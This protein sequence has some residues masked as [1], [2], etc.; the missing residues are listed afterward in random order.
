MKNLISIL[1]YTFLLAFVISSCSDDMDLPMSETDREIQQSIAESDHS[2]HRNCG[3]NHVMD[4]LMKDP[5]YQK[6]H[7][8]KL[9]K[10]ASMKNNPA[11]RS[12]CSN[13][14][15]IP[16]AVHF[17][18]VSGADASCLR[19]LAQSQIDILNN[20]F[21]GSNSD[22]SKWNNSAASFFPNISNGEACVK[23]VLATKN[24]PSGFGLSEGAIAVTI[25]KVQGTESS[26]FSGYLNIFVQPN[27]GFLGESP[28]GGAGNGDGVLVD[29]SA[30][31]SGAGCGNV[32]PESPYNLGRTLTT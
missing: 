22:I 4:K 16:V 12:A 5:E 20:D 29:A 9:R 11:L 18:S 21:A 24:H 3:M 32:S 8:E 14:T 13:P 31:G 15:L 23:F 6:V 1:T 17:Q 27:L 25:N 10:L 19:A 26:A 28:L 30:F 7:Q 2:K